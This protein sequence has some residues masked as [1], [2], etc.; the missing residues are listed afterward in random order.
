M[1]TLQSRG[2]LACHRAQDSDPTDPIVSGQGHIPILLPT[3]KLVPTW[4]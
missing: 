4:V 2:R 1:A 3:G